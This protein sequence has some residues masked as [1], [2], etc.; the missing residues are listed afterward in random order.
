MYS[1]GIRRSSTFSVMHLLHQLFYVTPIFVKLELFN[2][3]SNIPW[4]LHQEASF[5]KD[6]SLD[7]YGCDLVQ[8]ITEFPNTEIV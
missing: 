6:Q 7:R 4:S 8:V 5:R 3:K 1:C 2:P